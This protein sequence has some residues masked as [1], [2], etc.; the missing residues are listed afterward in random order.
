MAPAGDSVRHRSGT[1]KSEK[2][3]ISFV[4]GLVVGKN[5]RETERESQTNPREGTSILPLSFLLSLFLEWSL[6]HE[7]LLSASISFVPVISDLVPCSSSSILFFQLVELS[8]CGRDPH[9]LENPQSR[10]KSAVKSNRPQ[11]K[12]WETPRPSQ[13]TAPTLGGWCRSLAARVWAS[14]QTR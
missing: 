2:L 11:K 14:S 10:N 9:L 12:R 7:H 5:V 3:R 6:I 13:T 8:E 4:Q 1:A